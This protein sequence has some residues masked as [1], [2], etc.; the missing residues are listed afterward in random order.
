M[1]V[2]SQA[3]LLSQILPRQFR[4]IMTS[5]SSQMDQQDYDEQLQ[6]CRSFRYRRDGI[7]SYSEPHAEVLDARALTGRFLYFPTF[8]EKFEILSGAW[9]ARVPQ[10]STFWAPKL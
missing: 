2:N 6:R 8:W 4:Y 7:V 10:L 3:N 5:T 1:R 9:G